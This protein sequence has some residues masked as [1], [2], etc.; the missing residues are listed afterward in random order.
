MRREIPG[1][2]ALAAAFPPEWLLYVSL[3]CYPKHQAPMEIDAMIVLDD[4]VLILEIKDWNGK[5]TYSGDQWLVNGAKRGRSAVVA[6]GE[7]AKKLKSVIRTEIPALKSTWVD[8]RVVLT[9]TSTKQHL[10]A[11]EQQFVWTLKE[12]CSIADPNQRTQRLQAVRLG[13][14]KAYQFEQ[15]FD[16]FTGNT[17]L[18]Q[19]S[20]AAWGGFRIVTP[21]L[22]VHPA[23][24]WRD[25]GAE[26]R[27]EPRLKALVR[28]W[29]FDKL[30]VGLNSAER[31]QLI[32]NRELRAIAQLTAQGSDLLDRERILRPLGDGGEEILTQHYE[33]RSLNAGW[34]TLDRYLERERDG[35]SWEERVLIATTLL[36][37]VAGLHAS[38]IAHRDL[39]PRAL[40]VRDPT[41]M[42]V[43]GLMSCS[44]PGEETVADWL[45]VLSGYAANI[46]E[47]RR[48]S[49]KATGP[50]RD[51]YLVGGLIEE[52][53]TQR[54]REGSPNPW[55]LENS[56]W[57]P[58]RELIE[59]ATHTEPSK[60]FR[61]ARVMADGFGEIVDRTSAIQVDQAVLDH[62]EL[63]DIPYVCW[64]QS[65]TLSMTAARSVYICTRTDGL[66][67]TV[68]VWNGLRRGMNSE[69]DLVM[70]RLFEGVTRVLATPVEGLPHFVQ[71]GLSPVGPFVVYHHIVGLALDQANFQ[72]LEQ[73]AKLAEQLLTALAD[74]HGLG[75]SHGDIAPKNILYDAI[76]QQPYL[77]DAFDV[78][79]VGNGKVKTPAYCPVNWEVLGEQALD[80]FAIIKIVR[81]QLRAAEDPRAAVAIQGLSLELERPSIESLD[82][83]RAHVRRVLELLRAPPLPSFDLRVPEGKRA[84]R[85]DDERYY[86]VVQK[87]GVAAMRIKLSSLDAQLW[88]DVDKD[89]LLD[90][91]FA[92]LPFHALAA[93][94][95]SGTAIRARI[96]VEQGAT[97]G[98]NELLHYLQ[99][100][101]PLIQEAAAPHGVP[102][103][104][105]LDIPL[106]WNR[107]TELEEEARPKIEITEELGTRQGV[108]L[109]G[110]RTL[111]Q[112]FDF[113]PESTVDFHLSSGR[114]GGQVDVTRTDAATLAV[115][116]EASRLSVGDVVTLHDRRERASFDRRRK[117]ISRILSGQSA[118]PDLIS[119]FCPGDGGTRVDYGLQVPAGQ[120]DPYRLNDGQRDAFR[121]LLRYG[122]LGLL[123]GPPGTGKTH[124]IASI[125]HW[126]V[127]NGGARRVL[128]ASQSHE[129]VNNAIEALVSLFKRLG[130]RPSLLRIGSKGITAKIRPFHTQT[131]RERYLQ[132]FEGGLKS[133]ITNLTAAMGIKRS[134][135]FEVVEIDRSLG[136]LARRLDQWTELISAAKD[137]EDS[138]RYAGHFK[139]AA[140]AFSEASRNFGA[141]AL[142]SSQATE[143]LESL[144]GALVSKHPGTSPADVRAARS[145]VALAR[146]WRESLASPQRN[147]EE[148]LA[149]TRTIL[150][151]TCVGVG[152]TKIRIDAADFDWVIVDEAARCTP[153]ELAVPVQMGRRVLLVGDHLQLKPMI[154]QELIEKLHEEMPG[155]SEGEFSKSDFERAF[156]S[157]YGSRNGRALNEQY[158]M[159][160]AICRLVSQVFYEPH[161][162]RLQTSPA[163]GSTSVFDGCTSPGLRLPITWIDTTLAEHSHEQEWDTTFFNLAEVDSVI[164]VLECIAAQPALVDALEGLDE[165]SPIGVI[166]MYLGQKDRLEAAFAQHGWESRFKRL[167]RIDT[168]DAYQ[169]KEN[170]L[171]IVSLVRANR[172]G[173]PGHVGA[174]HRCNVAVSRAKDRL[175]LVGALRMWGA[176]P[177]N[178]PLREVLEFIRGNPTDAET[179]EPGN[180][181]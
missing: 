3:N 99:T 64:P 84:F 41:R 95:A 11:Q 118:I 37:I 13:L 128:I 42:A 123:Q 148:F 177:R 115:R 21:D 49:A 28:I 181:V 152:Q 136:L 103:S 81:E 19:P 48:Q 78:S 50:Q 45:P 20:E 130:G 133:R 139:R 146:D 33:V 70:I 106:Y 82:P 60:R 90:W 87:I 35:L 62:F 58:F 7:K 179:I 168:V 65:R 172:E 166:T 170:T 86:L 4:R 160:P 109:Y 121:D 140:E 135:S 63:T 155:M 75:A 80:R 15:D 53:L 40:W 83:A 164:K 14:I 159:H 111:G 91:R 141:R 178:R 134:L 108:V 44:L 176:L 74:L 96:S 138:A 132:R 151:A 10:S 100:H 47:D 97:Q 8:F 18:F 124:F 39:G 175:I 34:T 31:R 17:K 163:R 165:D 32:A 122:P 22:F 101:I 169:G 156:A 85:P 26:R 137:P 73:R 157:S 173:N 149:K 180:L 114:R 126:L 116:A 127:T 92:P 147:F 67:Y 161:H 12:A 125:V 6:V 54:S 93:V 56:P 1:V 25:H 69:T 16:R 5:L 55:S 117:A 162:I 129:A 167:V 88:L 79:P 24:I 104:L 27:S 120:L 119:Y 68:K 89:V 143:E 142:D 2:D 144:Y 112:G 66:E 9:A 61:D 145:A 43:S 110:Y 154:D 107:L 113:D 131:L 174:A 150:T 23:D 46:A 153:G 59:S 158:R 57:A 36:S 105:A 51:V 76:A 71:T 102:N 29:S 30:P 77:L 98:F 38:G 52:I 171:V 94:S 72:N